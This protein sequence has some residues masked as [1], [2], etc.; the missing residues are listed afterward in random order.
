MTAVRSRAAAPLDTSARLLSTEASSGRM[1]QYFDNVE[2]KNNVAVIK[3]NGPGKMNTISTGMQV[4]AEKIFKEMVLNNKDVK[5]VVFLS[6]KPDNFIAGADIDMIKAFEDKRDLKKLTLKA[7]DFFNELKK[8]KIPMVAG[9]NGVALGGG[10]EWALYCDYR[11]ATSSKKT[12]LGLPEVK[13]GLLPGMAGTYHLPKLVGY[14]TAMDMMLTGKNIRADKAKKMKLVDM[15]VDPAVLESVCIQ[16]ALGLAEGKVKPYQRKK[17]LMARLLED[18]P[19]RSIMFNKAK[20]A[21]DKNSG[22]HYPSPYA[23]LDVLQNNM[24]KSKQQHLEDEAQ[25]F[26][27]L[28]ATPVSEALIGLFH[29][30]TAVKKHD[31]G[32]PT[33]QVKNIAVLGAG[34]MGAGI[35]QVSVDNGKYRVLLKDKDV[36][37]ASRGE[38]VIVDEMKAKLKKKRMTNHEFC[39]TT[40][41]LVPLHDGVESWK[42]H[43]ASADLVIEAVFEEIGVKHRVL[44]EMEDIIPSHAIFASNTS[45][46]PIGK[47]A[48]GAKR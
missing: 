7:H 40:A 1:F 17:D 46:I 8:T 39:D 41:R 23:I 24:G 30:T 27:E 48:E 11:V 45:A 9:I 15:V 32:K 3:F 20:E 14:P 16:Q 4:E 22:G 13:L 18:T 44:K 12:A 28:A 47:I 37:G 6:S 43:F 5:A 19:L 26:S 21:V 2:I 42:K 33:H 34:L 35:A 29:G 31:F 38:K 25:K 36:A 10:L